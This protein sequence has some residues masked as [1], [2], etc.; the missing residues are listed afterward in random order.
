MLE[1]AL[2]IHS[3]GG[4]Q[5]VPVTQDRMS[6]GRGDAASICIDD[7]SLSRL[8]ASVFREGDKVW[9]A[10]EGS[11]NGTYVNDHPVPPV[12][13]ILAD[14]DEISL[15]NQTRISVCINRL[16]ASGA[17]AHAKTSTAFPS[18]SMVVS[19]M[20]VIAVLTGAWIFGSYLKAE[21]HS[22]TDT[23]S[24]AIVKEK[25]VMLPAG[26][27]VA[28]S[29]AQ[30]DSLN[31]NSIPADA[32]PPGAAPIDSGK[33]PETGVPQNAEN[34]AS[35]AA[36]NKPYSKM[37]EAEQREFIDR[38]AHR[39][40]TMIGN[41]GCTVTDEALG[42]IKY[43]VDAYKRRIGNRVGGG[44]GE[45]L[46]AIFKRA[47]YYGPIIGPAF[48]SRGIS[49][50]VAVYL[51][52]IETEYRP[53]CSENNKG[54]MGL[55]QFLPDTARAHGIDPGDRCDVKK[56][57]PAAA[58]YIAKRISE[59]GPDAIG[60]GLSIAGYNRDPNSVRRDLTNVVN[61]ENKERSF[62]TLVANQ[63]KLDV[64]FQKENINYVIRLYAFAI[65]GENPWAFGLDGMKPLTT[66]TEAGDR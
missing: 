8:H 61:S 20:L 37:T 5:Q 10:D 57:A 1:I 52:M 50:T 39:I 4:D 66:Y 65:I 64:Y 21:S 41:R 30:P 32:T 2:V 44:W 34:P 26:A 53:Y 46:V 59:F 22:E 9:I 3:P 31:R 23:D 6:L 58:D 7:R 56:M 54:A 16:A 24:G 27:G 38:E 55:F 33:A 14:G 28:L 35:S 63:D 60:V 13:T 42:R 40:A 15:G 43:W 36:A 47:I 45:D 48:K 49:A 17:G 29:N 25:N 19:S 18:L 51:P 62:W 11:I 12:G